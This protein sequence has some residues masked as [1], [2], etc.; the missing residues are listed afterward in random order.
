M[1]GA[2]AVLRAYEALLAALLAESAMPRLEMESCAADWT[3]CYRRVDEF[4][5]VGLAAWLEW[6]ISC[7]RR[8]LRPD[9]CAASRR[10][11]VFEVSPDGVDVVGVVLGV[12]VLDQERGPWMR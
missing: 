5:E 10:R 2:V 12:V 11:I 8:G 3:G 7:A 1:S 4:L 6:P 9:A